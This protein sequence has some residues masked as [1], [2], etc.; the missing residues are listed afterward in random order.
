MYIIS[1]LPKRFEVKY[2]KEHW[3]GWSL[4]SSGS[5]PG[6][7]AVWYKLY[8]PLKCACARGTVSADKADRDLPQEVHCSDLSRAH[9]LE[10]RGQL[11]NDFFGKIWFRVTLVPHKRYRE[12]TLLS[13]FF[14]SLCAH[15]GSM[16][17]VHFT[18]QKLLAYKRD[19]S[20]EI[21]CLEILEE[22]S[23]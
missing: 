6:C 9:L 10:V 7:G 22:N 2:Q 11:S 18:K 14:W 15:W 23:F 13:M 4:H 12:D 8:I 19:E 20:G 16:P 17:T 3:D 1:L 5:R 21:C